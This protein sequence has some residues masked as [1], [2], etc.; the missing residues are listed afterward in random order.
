MGN[1]NYNPKSVKLEEIKLL[2]GESKE[3]IQKQDKA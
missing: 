1:I 2:K 3:S